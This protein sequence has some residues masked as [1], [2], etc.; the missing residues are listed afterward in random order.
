MK[1]G[2]NTKQSSSWILVWMVSNITDPQSFW[3]GPFTL[4]TATWTFALTTQCLLKVNSRNA[5]ERFEI[6]LKLII[7]TPERH[8]S[9]V[10]FEQINICWDFSLESCFPRIWLVIMCCWFFKMC[11]PCCCPE[12]GQVWYYYY[13]SNFWNILKVGTKCID[14]VNKKII[15]H[16]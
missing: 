5:T 14:K 12:L 8:V 15:H 16:R 13:L 4:T 11:S 9:I 10:D 3:M 1:F 2:L 6:C 7:K